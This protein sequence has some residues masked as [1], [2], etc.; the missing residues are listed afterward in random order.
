MNTWVSAADARPLAA[1]IGPSC[2]RSCG[3]GLP[4]N[5]HCK[6]TNACTIDRFCNSGYFESAS[7]M[8]RPAAGV[9]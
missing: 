9:N 6:Q 8:S 3:R 1:L 7:E 2:I 4:A 5:G